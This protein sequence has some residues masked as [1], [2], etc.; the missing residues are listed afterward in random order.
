M[1]RSDKKTAWLV[2]G[3]L[4]TAALAPSPAA[5]A[6]DSAVWQMTPYEAQIL[7][8]FEQRPPITAELREELR[9]TLAERIDATIGAS[10][11]VKI[12]SA[13]PELRAAM[14][15]DFEGLQAKQIPLPYPPPDKVLTMSVICAPDGLVVKCRDF[16]AHTRTLSSPVRL[17]VGQIGALGDASLDALLTAFSPLARVESADRRTGKAVLR[18]KASG[19]PPRDPNLSFFHEHDVFQPIHRYNDREG[20]LKKAEPVPWNF[21]TVEK[22]DPEATICQLH[23]GLTAS[24]T[25]RGRRVESL[26]LRVVPTGDSTLLTLKSRTDPDRPLFGYQI[27]SRDP[28]ADKVDV[29]LLGRTDRRGQF[30]VPPSDRVLRIILVK[31]GREPLA[32]MPMV[33]GMEAEM[34]T[35]IANDDLRLWAEGFIYSLQEELVDIVARRKIYDALIRAR[36]DSGNLEQA[37]KMLEELKKLPDNEKFS[38][39][40]MQERDRLATDDPV[41]Q[42]KID[43]FLDDTNHLIHKH[44]NPRA[45]AEL[46]EMLRD[47]KETRIVKEREA[48]LKAEE[49]KKKAAEEA[50]KKAEEEKKKAEQEKS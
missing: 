22:S 44:L 18:L 24:L 6:D 15:H 8:A 36:I 28:Y 41:V 32:R 47:A 42:K 49:E 50:R 45:I 4:L 39:R 26:A 17:K 27:F 1:N 40:V 2:F 35:E 14:V 46:E 13:P 9:R 20:N 3:L 43:L 25:K 23:S 7:L 10:W 11:N 30:V 5:V 29:T 34:T 31:N 33:P 21:F 16:D 38:Y 48:K 12:L 37:E 19:L